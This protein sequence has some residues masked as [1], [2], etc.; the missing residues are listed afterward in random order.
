MPLT[1]WRMDNAHLEENTARKAAVAAAAKIA[2]AMNKPGGNVIH[3]AKTSGV[4]NR[5]PDCWILWKLGKYNYMR[6]QVPKNYPVCA[7]LTAEVYRTCE[8]A[9]AIP[10]TSKAIHS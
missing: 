4:A 9:A 7:I 1:C 10:V 5:R 3:L 2:E 8:R 6:P